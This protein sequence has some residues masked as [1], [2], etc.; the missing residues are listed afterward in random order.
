MAVAIIVPGRPGGASYQIV[1]ATA[2]GGGGSSVWGDHGTNVS[3]S[4]T[5]LTNDTATGLA[6]SNSSVRG[7][8]AWSTGKH[9]FEIKVLA[10]PAVPNSVIGLM[11]NT[12][13]NGAAMD[14]VALVNSAGNTEFNGNFQGNGW[15]GTNLGV[16]IS[17]VV[18]DVFGIAVDQT[19]Q[20]YYLSLNNVY[21]LSGDPTSGAL[22]T[23]AVGNGSGG[24]PGA[25]PMIAL[26]GNLANGGSYQ[27][28]TG[29]G[30]LLHLPSG[31]TA[32]G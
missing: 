31:Y 15:T 30:S 3:L 19:N 23:G 10:T 9:Y 22:G 16:A 8:Q 5:T 20:F 13:A 24:F 29:A 17:P 12:T 14:G 11:D 1:G 27:L 18:N 6:N 7:T 25:R 21:Y 2:G 4:T 28:I 26:W 32:W